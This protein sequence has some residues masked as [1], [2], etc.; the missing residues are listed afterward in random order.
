MSEKLNIL[1]VE[2]YFVDEIAVSRILKKGNV[3]F[4]LTRVETK[5]DYIQELSNKKY[6]LVVSDPKVCCSVSLSYNLRKIH[7]FR[8]SLIKNMSALA[9]IGL[10]L[11]PV[12]Y[13]RRIIWYYNS[14]QDF[15]R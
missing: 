3:S 7:K 9:Q 6:D 13:S 1:L 11:L 4:S 14:N 12:F 8:L 10:K 5:A 2:D 15:R